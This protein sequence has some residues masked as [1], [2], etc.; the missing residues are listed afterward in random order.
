M[1]L[2]N[3]TSSIRLTKSINSSRGEWAQQEYVLPSTYKGGDAEFVVT[4]QQASCLDWN[5]F[6]S[7][8][9]KRQQF[10]SFNSTFI[11]NS[12][13]TS[14]SK[15]TAQSCGWRPVLTFHETTRIKYESA[16]T[17]SKSNLVLCSCIEIK[18]SVSNSEAKCRNSNK[19]NRYPC[20]NRGKK[21][22]N[23]LSIKEDETCAT[24]M[25]IPPIPNKCYSFEL[26]LSS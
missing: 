10:N 24:K 4:K 1:A 8:N 13:N 17:N 3:F 22:N 5:N 7:L 19:L 23:Y 25:V 15:H 9:G 11:Q 14:I 12:T 20:F 2:L 18:Q 26:R 6:C 16:N 21:G